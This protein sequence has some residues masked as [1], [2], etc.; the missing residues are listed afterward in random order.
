MSVQNF[1]ASGTLLTQ[2]P[3]EYEVELS[4]SPVLH[5]C[6]FLFHAADGRVVCR[7]QDCRYQG[8]HNDAYRNQTLVV[9]LCKGGRSQFASCSTGEFAQL[10]FSF[11]VGRTILKS[12]GTEV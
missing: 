6:D 12:F 10:I 9:T 3:S 2:Q 7:P 4:P 1:T 8:G 5:G 11:I